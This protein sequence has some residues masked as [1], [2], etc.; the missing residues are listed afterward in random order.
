MPIRTA[1]AM[2]G[3]TGWMM[4]VDFEDNQPRSHQPET[5][6]TRGRYVAALNRV[7]CD[8]CAAAV[9]SAVQQI[10]GVG[11]AGVTS[12]NS[13]LVFEI[14]DGARVHLSDIQETLSSVSEALKAVIVLSGLRGP[15]PVMFSAA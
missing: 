12:T 2:H 13:M 3:A 15:M 7:D 4:A 5:I 8:G 14:M 11:M 6:L 9:E 1:A 10:H